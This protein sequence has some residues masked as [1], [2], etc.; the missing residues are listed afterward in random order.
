MFNRLPWIHR[1]LSVMMLGMLLS[2][3]GVRAEEP[4]T[5]KPAPAAPETSVPSAPTVSSSAT[6]QAV[7]TGSE[8]KPSSSDP[9]TQ[10]TPAVPEANVTTSSS[11]PATGQTAAEDEKQ[12]ALRQR[13][14]RYWAARQARD[15]KTV[16]EMESE[17]RPGGRLKLEH[18][19]SLQ[20]LPLRKAKIGE[21]KIEG[22][23]A[24]LDVKADV[25]V[26]TIG[27]VPQTA[28]RDRWLLLEG[29]WYHETAK[30]F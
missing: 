26:G 3:A 25:L 22:D 12:K 27:W 10:A 24:V 29:Q 18:A 1:Y 11:A 21:I 20:G 4:Q 28:I 8:A 5:A 17:A 13:A 19:M 14:E 15:V 2:A 6:V 7:P 9:Q 23:Q 16:F 30:D